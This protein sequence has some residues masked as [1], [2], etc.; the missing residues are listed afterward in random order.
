MLDDCLQIG[1]GPKRGRFTMAD[2]LEGLTQR[3]K[4]EEQGTCRFV[5]EC[6]LCQINIHMQSGVCLYVCVRTHTQETD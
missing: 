6:D 3:T 2:G 5:R 4:I 1:K